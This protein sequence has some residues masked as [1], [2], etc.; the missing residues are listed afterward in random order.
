MRQA[1]AITALSYIDSHGKE[2]IAVSR[3]E[4]DSIA[5][6]KDFSADPRFV[7]AVADKIWFGP[8]EFRRGSEPYMTI[9][10]AHVGK[11]PGVTVADVNLKLVWDV[12]S[13]IHVGANGFAYVVDDHGRLIAH[14]DLSLVLRDS[15]FS[16]LPQ[17]SEA[18]KGQSGGA[19][20][21]AKSLDGDAV[22]TAFAIEP[23]THWAVFVEQP[24]SEALAAAYATLARAGGLLGLGLLLAAVTGVALAR[25]MAAPIRQLQAGAENLGAGDLAQRL[26][27]RTGDEIEALAGSFN[28]MAR[29]L[30]ESYETLEAKVETRTKDLSE[31]LER[32]TATAEI[33]KVIAGSPSDTQPVFE[34]IVVTAVRLLGCNVAAVMLRDG[35]AFETIAAASPKGRYT[36]KTS[37]LPID[38][39][40]NFPSRAIVS[41]ETLHLPDW[42]LIDL[43][44]Q[45]RKVRELL[46]AECALYL[47]LQR[48]GECFALLSLLAQR[49]NAFGP[50]EIAL[51]ESFGDQALIAIE[52]VRLF[53]EVT[54]KTRD[55]EE[56]L[57]QQTATADVLKVISRSA[58]DLDAVL[59]TL[60]GSAITLCEAARGIIW[61]RRG[62]RLHRAAHI[63]YP[64]DWVWSGGDVPIAPAPDATSVS[65]IAAFTGEVVNI[66]DMLSDPRFDELT[67]RRLGGH[68]GVLAVPM[69]RDGEVVGVISLTRPEARRFTD[70]Q[71]ALVKA[72]ADQAVIAIEN[73]RLFDAVQ[74]RTRELTEALQQ[75]TATADVLKVISRSAFDLQP[76]LDTLLKS[77]FDLIGATTGVISLREGDQLRIKSALSPTPGVQ[78][79]LVGLAVPPDSSTVAG[80]AM[81][82]GKIEYVADADVDPQFR[83]LAA[84]RAEHSFLA[85]PL[86]RDD[87]VE[88]VI[89]L[90]GQEPNAFT[91][92]HIALVQT[93]ADQA[94]IAVENVR[95]FDEV[96]A[97]TRDLEESLAQQTATADV[98]KAISRSAFDLDVVLETL[99]STAVRLCDANGG[100]I[101]RRHGE[102]F[103][104]AA[105]KME[106]A[107]AYLEHEQTTQIGPG[108]GTLV[109]RV[110]LEGRAVQIEDAWND[111][112]YAEKAEARI[113]NVRAMLGVPLLRS[114]ELIGAFALARFEPVAFSQRQVELVQTFADQAVIAIENA[115]L[116]A[117]VQ[118]RTRDLEESL[119]QQTATADVL[120]VISRSAFDL[121]VVLDTLV[122]SASQLC[123]VSSG[124]IFL[125]KG[126]ALHLCSAIN[127]QSD[128]IVEELR[129]NPQTAG[130]GSVASRVLLTGEVQNVADVQQDADYPANLKQAIQVRALLGVPL[131]RDD[132]VVG[133]FVLRR[134]EPGLFDTRHVDLVRTFADQ[135]VIAV[136]NA[137]LL[138]EVRART[139]DL[140]KSLAQQTATADV[141]KV[142][143]R[144][145]FDLDAIF[146]TL[147]TTAVDLCGASSGTLCVR[148][149]DA[150]RYRGM[151][152]PAATPELQ[153]YLE[154]HPLTRVT[155]QTAAGRAILSRQTEQIEDVLAE[156]DYIVP[157][158][159]HGSPARSLLGVPLIGKTEVLGA[160]VVAR[161]EPGAFPPR[162]VEI[163]R[164]FADQAVIAIEN[165]RLFEQVQART[166]ELEDSL[167]QQ[168]ATADVLKVINRSAF[169]LQAVLDTLVTSAVGLFGADNG[170]MYLQRGQAFYVRAA[171]N[172]AEFQPI[173]DRLREQP[174]HPGRGSVGARV[175]LTGETQHVPDLQ[176]DPEYDPK[177]RA[178][179]IGKAVLGVPMKRDGAVVGAI[180]FVRRE[181]VPYSPRHIEIAQTFADQAVIAVENARLFE[182]VQART[183][184]L[185]QSL[186]DLRNAQDRLVQS[187]K[188]AS[189]GQLTAGIAH[190]IKNPLNFVNNF[191]SLSRE[192]LEE[193][194]ETL[195]GLPDDAKAEAGDLMGMINSNLEKVASH[196]KRADSIVKN[197]LLHSREGS[198]ERSKVN[199][200][201]MVEEALNL[202]YHGARAEKPG[203]NVTI[204]K[205]FDP[206]AGEADL[207]LQEVTR[208]LLNLIS[209]GFY[210][211]AK[212]QQ[213]EGP[214]YEPTLRAA[215]RALGR[216]VEI[217]IRDNGTGIPDDVRARM[218]NPFFTTKPAGE[219]TGLGL[220]LSHDIVVK[221]H[222]G[223]L[224]VE[225]TP[226]AFT[227]FVITLPREGAGT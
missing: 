185:E 91:P 209:N 58:F 139:D 56:A 2:Q 73:T 9:A 169:D 114:G 121:Q 6:G 4:P 108:R 213:S 223:T 167:A 60:V 149:G 25:R 43:P 110:A 221:Q 37:R 151:A 119:A 23:K 199:V 106:V 224:D 27:I 131:K 63:N 150:F 41:K 70:R 75:Q 155:R 130:R 145:A 201:A 86:T 212:R 49:A 45:E 189:L 18:L 93:F 101:F 225:T 156:E 51:A 98:L 29:S 96:Q 129:R 152:G 141:L 26:D 95:L 123:G 170:I 54:A 187:E 197:M 124:L 195:G 135:A 107:P 136:E 99:V 154:T 168:T 42:S 183:R 84:G 153:R 35:G 57:Q 69:D 82:S 172:K 196:G 203:F 38:P 11:T 117:A 94:V 188:L 76:I 134:D 200:N 186:S 140:E 161:A 68:R 30:Q 113:G 204:E 215:T 47:P 164:T 112:E 179:A 202:G 182:E 90:V 176:A 166:R 55:L 72:F 32:Q 191:A 89:T 210:A 92:R 177:F 61:M 104:Y 174:H 198:G 7:R 142:I 83:R 40:A 175:L 138:D 80:R 226:G 120:K 222:G 3:L 115:R 193:L 219:G 180:V 13:A 19:A 46:G 79:K 39:S 163:L 62:D 77:A 81:T 190:E 48:E 22:L 217:R 15:D 165:S 207:Y 109:G 17:V 220:S 162:H 205:A 33:L 1:P 14:P 52:N 148:E 87:R 102:T 85:V 126:D 34:S 103:R 88:G 100:Q 16:Q 125:K 53:T 64:E 218:F 159:A 133:A 50:N 158:S 118:E 184:E 160:I 74:A 194:R 65:G 36:P 143:S 157:F 137:R 216:S 28:R 127:T 192:L 122:G 181:A 146:E 178:A 78:E 171:H 24:L 128:P 59:H 147:V 5:S 8:V 105:S 211:S 97:R 206:D 67:V 214:G 227:E 66:E 44:E 10:L 31:A 12:V 111:P 21:A 132:E 71:V 20:A 173:V 208:V 116:F 144:S